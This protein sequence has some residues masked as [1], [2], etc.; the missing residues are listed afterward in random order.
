M[1][2]FVAIVISLIIS[3]IACFSIVM[4]TAGLKRMM[5]RRLVQQLEMFLPSPESSS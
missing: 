3:W 4:L 1:S 2:S 5:D